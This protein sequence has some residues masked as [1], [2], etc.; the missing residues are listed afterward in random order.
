MVIFI[1]IFQIGYSDIE[2]I[3]VFHIR[4]IDNVNVKISIR[5]HF[6]KGNIPFYVNIHASPAPYKERDALIVGTTD[7][8]EMLEKDSQLI[9]ASKMS[10]L[11]EMSAGIAHELNQPLNA[12]KMGSEFLKMMIE[13]GRKIA[14]QQ[15]Y[16]V[17]REVEFLVGVDLVL[18]QERQD[19]IEYVEALIED[20][21]FPDRHFD[22]VICT[23]VM[24]HILDFSAALA[25]LRR[26]C[27]GTLI[28]VVPREREYIYT[29]NPHFHFFPYRESLLR[30]MIPIPG[31]FE[32][33]NIGRDIYYSETIQ[34]ST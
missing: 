32:C 24:E 26:I 28:V 9:Q 8:T 30:R 13:D 10:T 2:I 29:F 20:L 33:V 19:G 5:F 4:Q 17:V 11:G 3:F 12:I 14:D 22:T 15:L 34:K 18:P 31:T 16:D 7:I 21:P 23:H 1:L 6:K 25:E 27:A